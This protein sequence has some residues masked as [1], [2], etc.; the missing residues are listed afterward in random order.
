MVPVEAALVEAV[1]R[2]LHSKMRDPL[3]GQTVERLV[4][5]DGIGRGEGAVGRARRGE[6]AEGAE[7]RRLMTERGE[8]LADEIGDRAFPAGAGHGDDGAGLTRVQARRRRAPRAR[9][10][11]ADGDVGDPLVEV[12]RAGALA[13]DRDR[14]G[15]DSL[16]DERDAVRLAARHGDEHRARRH[17]AAVGGEADDRSPR[18]RAAAASGKRSPIVA[19]RPFMGR[20]ARN[21]RRSSRAPGAGDHER[22]QLRRRVEMRRQP[23]SGATRSTIAPVAGASSRRRW[24][25]R[26]FPAG[27]AARPGP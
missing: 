10:T 15:R 5:G 18:E 26:A 3:P 13:D 27:P 17:L 12:G 24:R 11:S 1:R 19:E 23:S 21:R 22:E 9:R 4:Q 16:R 14:A 8:E 6:D 25:S 20:F 7:A 2:R